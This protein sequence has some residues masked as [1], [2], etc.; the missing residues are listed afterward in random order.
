M[1]YIEQPQ[2]QSLICYI[3]ALWCR[4]RN[5]DIEEFLILTRFDNEVN[6][7]QYRSLVK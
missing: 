1:S 2:Y 3:E 5:F 6:E 4:S 7:L